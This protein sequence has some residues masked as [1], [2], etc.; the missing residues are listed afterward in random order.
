[1]ILLL[2]LVLL[3]GTFI[4]VLGIN[5]IDQPYRDK[6]D[7]FVGIL[8]CLAGFGVMVGSV[9]GMYEIGS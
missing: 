9:L 3:M 6:L 2:I 7:W 8:V 1:M 4:F 5:V